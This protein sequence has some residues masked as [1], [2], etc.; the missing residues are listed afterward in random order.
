MTI[1]ITSMVTRA[2]VEVEDSA[3]GRWTQLNW[4]DYFNSA[5]KEICRLKFDA[6]TKRANVVLASGVIQALPSDGHRL[7]RPTRNMGADGV[8]VGNAVRFVELDPQNSFS[9]TWYSQTNGTSV[10]DVFYDSRHPLEF[11][12]SPPASTYYLEII[13]AAI[14]AVVVIGSNFPLIDIYETPAIYFAKGFAHQANRAD[15]DFN[16]ANAFMELAFSSLGLQK[17][18]EKE[19]ER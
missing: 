10:D 6:Y 19:T 11:F 18:S 5:I 8:T 4:V 2:A 9:E 1:T 14:P 12:V 7:I 13:Y 16:R 17:G 15:V 3:Y